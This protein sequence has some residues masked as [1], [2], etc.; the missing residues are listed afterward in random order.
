MIIQIEDNWFPYQLII[1]GRR[2]NRYQQRIKNFEVYYSRDNENYTKD[3]NDFEYKRQGDKKEYFDLNAPHNT[4]WLKIKSTSAHNHHTFRAGL[5]C[6]KVKPI[7][8]IKNDEIF[9]KPIFKMVPDQDSAKTMIRYSDLVSSESVVDSDVKFIKLIGVSL[10]Q[11][12]RTQPRRTQ[13]G[14]IESITKEQA[15]N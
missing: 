3:S 15:K 4:R 5:I 11:P 13:P 10:S 8:E 6:E 14:R 12:R 1:Q 9:R 7:I 2:N